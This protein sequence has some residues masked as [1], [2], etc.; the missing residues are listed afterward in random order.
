MWSAWEH[1][2]VNTPGL[3]KRWI[4]CQE[5]KVTAMEIGKGGQIWDLLKN[6]KNWK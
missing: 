6:D 1:E 2:G 4:R 5:P 3:K